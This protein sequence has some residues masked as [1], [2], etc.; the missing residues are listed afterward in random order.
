LKPHEF[1]QQVN[2]LKD[3]FGDRNYS[4]ERM[5]VIWKEVGTLSSYWLSSVID[6]FIGECRQAPLMPEFRE[7]IAKERERLHRIEKDVHAEEAKEF[8]DGIYMPEDK[9]TICQYIRKRLRGEVSDADFEVFIKHLNHAG[10]GVSH[11]ISQIG[12]RDCD[13]S[14]LVFHR[15]EE[16]Y[17]FVY[18]CYCSQGQK[19]AKSYAVWPRNGLG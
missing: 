10:K 16:N 1:D 17:E 9:K 12:C 11:K 13:G 14:G 5:K 4:D 8:F 18:R 2:R 3:C 19:Q 6:Q 15:N 7:Q